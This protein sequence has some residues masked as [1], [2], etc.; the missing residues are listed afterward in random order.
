MKQEETEKLLRALIWTLYKNNKIN[1]DDLHEAVEYAHGTK[2]PESYFPGSKEK[3]ALFY[4]F[5]EDIKKTYHKLFTE[6]MIKFKKK[7][8]DK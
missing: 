7:N 1:L 4:V 6:E 8:K 3:D 5:G 2:L